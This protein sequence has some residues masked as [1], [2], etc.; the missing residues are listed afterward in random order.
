MLFGCSYSLMKSQPYAELLN[1]L[2]VCMCMCVFLFFVV[3]YYHHR[4]AC[5]GWQWIHSH[6]HT[7]RI[8]LCWDTRREGNRALAHP[9]THQNLRGWERNL[10]RAG[11]SITTHHVAV[12]LERLNSWSKKVREC[13]AAP[14]LTSAAGAID[15]SVSLGAGT[16]VGAHVINTL[17][18]GLTGPGFL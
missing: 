9:H 2:P 15:L 14:A 1:V 4:R 7:D 18:Y 8:P 11:Q 3:L 10:L 16:G 12:T 13:I 17:S 5:R 6:T